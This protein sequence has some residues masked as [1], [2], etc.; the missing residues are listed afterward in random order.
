MKKI[1]DG[2]PTGLIDNNFNFLSIISL[3]P[4]HNNIED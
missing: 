4:G 2:F 1:A 3:L